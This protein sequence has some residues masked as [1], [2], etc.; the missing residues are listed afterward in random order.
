[1]FAEKL[2]FIIRV[3]NYF[4]LISHINFVYLSYFNQI[5]FFKNI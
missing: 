2:F 1:M 4:T 5:K 3:F